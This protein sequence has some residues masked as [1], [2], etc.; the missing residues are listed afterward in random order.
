MRKMCV[1]RGANT[2][3]DTLTVWLTKRLIYMAQYALVLDIFAQ[4][5]GI[6][7]ILILLLFLL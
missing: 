2:R 7:E 4:I 3:E 5:L 1:P 6:F